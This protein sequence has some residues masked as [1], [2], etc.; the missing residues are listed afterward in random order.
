MP[1][2]KIITVGSINKSSKKGV[3]LRA[4]DLSSWQEGISP[5]ALDCDIVIIKV[6]GGIR[7][8]NPY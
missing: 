3:M 1:N 2:T 5:A 7:Y 8:I 6:T 4:V